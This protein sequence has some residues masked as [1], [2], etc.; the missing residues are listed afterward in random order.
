MQ[1]LD[2]AGM[3]GTADLNIPRETDMEC[4]DS[5]KDAKQKQMQIQAQKRKTRSMSIWEQV[6]KG[7]ERTSQSSDTKG[8]GVNE[9]TPTSVER[10]RSASQQKGK[11][12]RGEKWGAQNDKG[13]RQPRSQTGK[14]G[15][16]SN[17]TG[18]QPESKDTKEERR[19]K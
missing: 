3:V 14:D 15:K 9:R 7:H 19:K 12:K 18:H 8:K 13:N 16:E 5:K 17:Y 4:A 11:E 10:G 1:T 2:I 6:Y